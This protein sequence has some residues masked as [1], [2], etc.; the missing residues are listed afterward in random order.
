MESLRT[1]HVEVWRKSYQYTYPMRQHGFFGEIVTAENGLAE[2]SRLNDSTTTE[3]VRNWASHMIS[4]MTPSNALWFGLYMSG[5]AENEKR[6]LSQA[7][8][9][10]WENIHNSNFDSLAFEAMIDAACAGWF[11]LYID[12]SKD[13]GYHF[14]LW[15]IPE[16]YIA[17]SRPGQPV[18]TIYRKFKLRADQAMNQYGDECSEK[19]KE[20]IANNKPHE[21]FEFVHAIYPRESGD[22]NSKFAKNLPFASVHV[23]LKTKTTVR[24]SG[25]HE[26][27]CCVP[28]YM[29]IPGTPYPVGP[30]Y[31]ALPDAA[32][33][34]KLREF[35][36]ANLDMAVGGLWIAEDDGVLNPRAIKIGARRVIVA[37][38][39]D[40]M[41]PL[42][43]STDFNV[44]FM[45]E[46]RIQGQI[47]KILL[48]DVLPPLEGQPRTATEINERMA[49]LRQMLGPVY[50]RLES[51]YLQVMIQRCFGLALRAGALGKPPQSMDGRTWHVR[52]E[53]PLARAQKM[54]EV[55]AIDQYVSG[56]MAAAQVDPSVLDNIDLDKAAKYRAEALGVPADLI[57]I[58]KDIAERRSERKQMQEQEQQEQIASELQLEAGKQAIQNP[59][60]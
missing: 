39:V 50:G 35:E 59:A 8:R 40:S 37:N 16:C 48:A 47:R 29:L 25:Y 3:A 6:F 30:V 9:V 17:S 44:A 5:Q 21:K 56:L 23:E 24:E 18:D 51:E 27:P 1:Q 41:K 7:A 33:L 22:A 60:A 32:T 58:E 19:I 13:G 31:D 55:A 14:E 28:R 54:N 11:V 4:G 2:L 34:N 46:D 12:E 42:Q 57:P 52:Y 15:P 26:F 10:I 43:S 49:W 20:A 53:S 38:S 45:S 36:F